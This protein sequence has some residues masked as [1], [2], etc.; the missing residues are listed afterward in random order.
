MIWVAVD[1]PDMVVVT[2]VIAVVPCVVVHVLVKVF[3]KV[4]L[5]EVDVWATVT[6]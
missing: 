5:V 2:T 4:P 6:V 1:V 3:V